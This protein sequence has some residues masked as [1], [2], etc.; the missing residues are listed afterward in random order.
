MC[1]VCMAGICSVTAR[2][3]R[4]WGKSGEL[5]LDFGGFPIFPLWESCSSACSTVG[6]PHSE[7]GVGASQVSLSGYLPGCIDG[8]GEV[9][10]AQVH[11]PHRLVSLFEGRRQHHQVPLQKACLWLC[12]WAL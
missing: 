3:G 5:K 2:R 7:E 6:V 10:A 1:S 8:K 11:Q 9:A 4:G 12:L